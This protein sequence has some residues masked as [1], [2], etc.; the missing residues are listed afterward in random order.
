MGQ[1]NLQ[2]ETKYF[3][4]YMLVI[5]I[6]YELARFNEPNSKMQERAPYNMAVTD[7]QK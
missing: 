1:T 3:Q 2:F 5:F 7:T 6:S 4:E